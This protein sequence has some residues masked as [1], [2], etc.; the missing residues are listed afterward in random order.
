MTQRGCA[1]DP[2]H[3]WRK[4]SQKV[5]GLSGRQRRE[6]REIAMWLVLLPPAVNAVIDLTL[7]HQLPPWRQLEPALTPPQA[8]H[9]GALRHAALI[10]NNLSTDSKSR[11]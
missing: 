3:L 2:P 11:K 4:L 5:N 10:S 1:G 7:V 6:W 9:C 8:R